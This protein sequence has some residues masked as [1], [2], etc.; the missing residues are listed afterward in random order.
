MKPTLEEVKAYF[1]NA[2]EVKCL[3]DLEI[4]DISELEIKRGEASN[5]S[6]FAK[7]KQGCS[8]AELYYN[9]EYAEILSNL[10]N[11]LYRTQAIETIKELMTKHEIKTTEL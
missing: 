4:Y 1:K 9:N 3:S 6:Y 11:E 8:I 10:D 5:K 7:N 2:K